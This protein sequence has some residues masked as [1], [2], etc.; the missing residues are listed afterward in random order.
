MPTPGSLP[1]IRT[2]HRS[3]GPNRAGRGNRSASSRRSPTPGDF[4]RGGSGWRLWA[5]GELL[6]LAPQGGSSVRRGPREPAWRCEG[7]ALP[8][9]QGYQAMA[10]FQE[11]GGTFRRRDP[12]QSSRCGK[13]A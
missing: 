2:K 1:S 7:R 5:G 12:G 4:A 13:D 6:S 10:E 3:A 8:A 9:A 11:P